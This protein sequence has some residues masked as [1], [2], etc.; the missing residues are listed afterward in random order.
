MFKKLLRLIAIILIIIFVVYLIVALLAWIAAGTTF[1]ASLSSF[2][3]LGFVTTAGPWAFFSIA[4]ASAALAHIISPDE[5][6]KQ[7]SRVVKGTKFVATSLGS[8]VGGIITGGLTG[9]ISGSPLMAIAVGVGVYLFFRKDGKTSDSEQTSTSRRSDV[10]N[11]PV[12]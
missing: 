3:T 12:R 1:A 4:F 9:L 7:M 10:N 11:E 2:F 6:K 5:A 8:G